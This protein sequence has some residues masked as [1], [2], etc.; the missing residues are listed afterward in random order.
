MASDTRHH[1]TWV[2]IS[3]KKHEHQS[4]QQQLNHEKSKFYRRF[5][6]LYFRSIVIDA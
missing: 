5:N 3:E 1:G 2:I 4:N 6:P